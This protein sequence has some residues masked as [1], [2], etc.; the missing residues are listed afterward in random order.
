LLELARGKQCLAL[1]L[2]LDRPWID[3]VVCALPSGGHRKGKT[4]QA[5]NREAGQ[6]THQSLHSS[7]GD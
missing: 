7:S 1:M 3:L 2:Q 6:R 4:S 5:D